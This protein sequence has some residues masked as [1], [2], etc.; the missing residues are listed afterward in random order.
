MRQVAIVDLRKACRAP[1]RVAGLGN[2]SEDRLAVE[3]DGR[4]AAL[5][6]VTERLRDSAPETLAAFRQMGVI[7][8]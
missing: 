3:L 4:P 8:F 7:A 5:A 6:V 1:C 2:H